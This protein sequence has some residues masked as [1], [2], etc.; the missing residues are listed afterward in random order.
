MA[1]LQG[2]KITKSHSTL[3]EVSKEVVNFLNKLNE[4]TKISIGVISNTGGS[5]N[6]LWSVKIIDEISC[7]LIRTTQ[8]STNQ[9]IRFYTKN[10]EDRQIAKDALAAWV[11]NKGW[12]VRFQ[13]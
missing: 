4:V 9:Q 10:L 2:S 7:V 5:A 12:Q 6:P 3:S 11:K 13:K 1:H 8:K